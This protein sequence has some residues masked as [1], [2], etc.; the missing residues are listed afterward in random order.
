VTDEEARRLN[1]RNLQMVAALT[2]VRD[3]LEADRPDLA[4]AAC[5]EQ[6]ARGW[7]DGEET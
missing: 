7:A 2:A 6:L 4:L 1:A 5:D 3:L